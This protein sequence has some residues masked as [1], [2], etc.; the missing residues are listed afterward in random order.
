LFVWGMKSQAKAVWYLYASVE[1][2][3]RQTITAWVAVEFY[4]MLVKHN[5]NKLFTNC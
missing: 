2:K 3:I 5:I 1:R 4:Q